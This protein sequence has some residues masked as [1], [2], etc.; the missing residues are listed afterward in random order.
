[1][2][3]HFLDLETSWRCVVSFTLRPSRSTADTYC[4]ADWVDPKAELD[5]MDMEK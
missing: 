4:T 1:M 5:Y 3:P 2:D